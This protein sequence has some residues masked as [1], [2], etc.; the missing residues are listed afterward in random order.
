MQ[1]SRFI[2]LNVIFRQLF[3]VIITVCYCYCNLY[4]IFKVTNI[5]SYNNANIHISA[6]HEYIQ[7]KKYDLINYSESVSLVVVGVNLR[8]NFIT[9][10]Y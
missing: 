8:N 1:W 6:I 10:T 9:L 5:A 7:Y 4:S 3:T 2:T